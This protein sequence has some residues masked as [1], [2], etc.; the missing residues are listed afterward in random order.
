MLRKKEFHDI[1]VIVNE[2]VVKVKIFEGKFSIP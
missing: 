1:K 2:H